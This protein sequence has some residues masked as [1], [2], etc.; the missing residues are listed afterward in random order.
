MTVN[1]RQARQAVDCARK[2]GVLLVEAMWTR[3]LPL[4]VQI[5][6]RLRGGEFGGLNV[7][8]A[9]LTFGGGRLEQSLK[10]RHSPDR[11]FRPELAGGT[12]LDEGS[13]CVSYADFL[14]GQRPVG[15]AAQAAFTDTGVDAITSAIFR[16]R[17][18]SM[19]MLSCSLVQSMLNRAVLFCEK[20]TL[21]V[22]NFHRATRAVIR[23]GEGGEE[24]LDMP[25]PEG[26]SGLQ[27]EAEAVMDA[28]LAGQVECPGMTWQNTIDVMETLDEIRR[29]VGLRYP[30][31]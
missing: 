6:E 19:A 2:Q 3:F 9:D 31:E 21:T 10:V 30:F 17:N 16:Y 4:N 15:I 23:H 27:Y 20:A 25:W 14:A 5:R 22:E 8:Q 13:Y 26:T 12:L 11:L 7:M 29:M 28:L 24:A 18:G 1:A